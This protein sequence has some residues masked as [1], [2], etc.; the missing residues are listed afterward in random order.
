[1]QAVYLFISI[2]KLFFFFCS[3]LSQE[4]SDIRSDIQKETIDEEVREWEEV[5]K[6]T[7]KRVFLLDFIQKVA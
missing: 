6:L 4:L 5:P 7:S 1:M 3:Q 2:F